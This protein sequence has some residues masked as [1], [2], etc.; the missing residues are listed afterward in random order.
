MFRKIF[1]LASLSLATISTAGMFS[2]S[3]LLKKIECLETTRNTKIQLVNNLQNSKSEIIVLVYNKESEHSLR[4]QIVKIQD[5]CENVQIK[6]LLLV[7][8]TD[9][10]HLQTFLKMLK[11][12]ESNSKETYPLDL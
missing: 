9:V 12:Q 4:E 2:N 5:I 6:K 8:Q 7:D 10:R 1:N 3:Y 11:N